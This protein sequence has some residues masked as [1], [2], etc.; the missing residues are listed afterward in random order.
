M[1]NTIDIY[2]PRTMGSVVRSM[3][4]LVTFLRDRYFTSHQHY[5]TERVD[6][7]IVK[8]GRPMAPFV[9]YRGGAELIEKTGYDTKTFTIPMLAPATLTE[10]EELLS[11][12]PGEAVYSGM[13]PEQRAV[14]KLSEEL[15]QLRD[16]I[17]RREEWMCA[18]LLTTGKIPVIG[19][20][21]KAEVDVNFTNQSTAGTKWD[22]TGAKILED[23]A[24]AQDAVYKNGFLYATDFILGTEAARCFVND[25]KIQKLLDIKDYH[26]GRVAPKGL[27]KGVRYIG[28]VSTADLDADV[29]TYNEHFVDPTDKKLKPLIPGHKM[30]CLPDNMN[31]EMAYGQVTYLNQKTQQWFSDNSGRTPDQWVEK[32]PDRKMVAMYSRPLPVPK[33]VNAWYCMDVLDEVTA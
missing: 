4:P 3:P 13:S 18:K 14:R 12:M 7:D 5:M 23:M 25:T 27:P 11:R 15:R 31:A 9:T 10:A 28:H 29:Y 6:F 17:D 30:L 20:Q 19:D 32:N 2:S 1:P 8:G 26:I 33:E 22:A 24:L 21:I 16:S